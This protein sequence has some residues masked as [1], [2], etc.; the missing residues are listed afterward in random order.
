M[1]ITLTDDQGNDLDLDKADGGTL[2]RKLEEAL[3]ENRKLSE[4]VVTVKAEKAIGEHGK[5]LVKAE[6]LKGVAPDEVETKVKE[7]AEKRL[8]E[9]RDVL[10][11]VL[12]TRD[13]LEG[14]E[15][16]AA[17]E[18]FLDG[19]DSDEGSG[20]SEPDLT[21]LSGLGGDRP[22]TKPK[23]PGLDDPFGNLESH[24][25]EQERRSKRRK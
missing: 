2:R 3:A 25:E 18:D 7:I 15:L 19:G 8:Q 13:G 20:D 24:F 14:D 4:A 12:R 17:V 10:R 6:D 5:G 16:E 1:P 11:D 23:L 22:A 21:D 9:R